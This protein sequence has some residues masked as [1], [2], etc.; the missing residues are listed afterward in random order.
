[1]PK[2]EREPVI[3]ARST[4]DIKLMANLSQIRLSG[5]WLSNPAT[6]YDVLRQAEEMVK[7]ANDNRSVI[8][9]SEYKIDSSGMPLLFIVSRRHVVKEENHIM[10]I[11]KSLKDGG[12]T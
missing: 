10:C 1:M 7:T 6:I 8:S 2:V 11:F 5:D 9:T 3:H 4:M 12:K